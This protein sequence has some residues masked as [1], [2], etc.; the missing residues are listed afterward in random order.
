M[1]IYTA[2]ESALLSFVS[3]IEPQEWESDA[4]ARLF[5]PRPRFGGEGMGSGEEGP[6]KNSM[7]R[8]SSPFRGDV[9]MPSKLPQLVA[10]MFL[11]TALL[12]ADGLAQAGK[13]PSFDGKALSAWIE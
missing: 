6:C 1:Q 3:K 4:L 8:P 7:F 10:A 12:R 9:V 13:E 5:S 2:I 11:G